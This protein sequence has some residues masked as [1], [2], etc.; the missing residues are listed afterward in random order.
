[1]AAPLSFLRRS[2]YLLG[3]TGALAFGAATAAQASTA[4]RSSARACPAGSAGPCRTQAAC[5][6]KCDVIFP[7]AE[8]FGVC[9]NECCFCLEP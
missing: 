3:I 2:L 7:P 5:Q 8:S 9:E 1:M 6:L 4:A